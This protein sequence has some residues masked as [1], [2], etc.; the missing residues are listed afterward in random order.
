MPPHLP[1]L[2]SLLHTAKPQLRWRI[3]FEFTR[4]NGYI[5]GEKCYGCDGP[6]AKNFSQMDRLRAQIVA[7]KQHFGLLAPGERPSRPSPISSEFR[8]LPPV[9]GL[10]AGLRSF[11]KKSLYSG[12][13]SHQGVLTTV[14]E[15]TRAAYYAENFVPQ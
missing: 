11:T 1:H 10:T 7:T 9:L 6:Y 5:G 14:L 3:T 2:R 15:H 4:E 8:R 13:L 12:R